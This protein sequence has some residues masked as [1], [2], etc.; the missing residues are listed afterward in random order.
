MT[1]QL[2]D[3]A[4]KVEGFLAKTGMA[5][6][7]F[8]INA[9]KSGNLVADLRRGRKLRQPTAAKVDDYIRRR[10]TEFNRGLAAALG[11]IRAGVG[12]VMTDVK[13]EPVNLPAGVDLAM[14]KQLVFS[15]QLEPGKDSFLGGK[16]QTY[17][18]I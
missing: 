15:G 16:P 6:S 13:G 8:G 5:P 18:P 10:E 14:F 9:V 11:K 7:T 1:E 17:R 3:I 2:P 12:Y 4:E